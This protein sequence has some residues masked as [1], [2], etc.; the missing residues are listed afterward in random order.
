MSLVFSER[1]LL[2]A[3][4]ENQTP[5]I[6]QTKW[7]DLAQRRRVLVGREEVVVAVRDEAEQA[8]A[9]PPVGGDRDAREAVRLLDR[10]HVAYR[11][12]GPEHR[13]VHDEALLEALH[14]HANRQSPI[15]QSI[16]NPLQ[17]HDQ[18]PLRL[19]LNVPLSTCT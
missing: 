12:L 16:V 6:K 10:Q 13:R 15:H 1:V 9:E 7:T 4:Q 14:A 19:L 8:P 5:D 18:L 17:L 2:S 11:R 3:P